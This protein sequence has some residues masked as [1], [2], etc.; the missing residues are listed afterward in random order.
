MKPLY[1]LLFI[2]ALVLCASCEKELK[3]GGLV[4]IDPIRH[5]YPVLQ[6]EP[7]TIS[8]EMEDTTDIPI[9]I[10]EVQT[11]CG[12]IV[13]KTSLPLTVLP[14]KKAFLTLT[15]NTIKNTGYVHH[16]I[17]CYGNFSD[18]STVVLEFDTNI[19]PGADYVRDYEELWTEQVHRGITVR[20]MVDGNASEKGYYTDEQES[21]RTR[22][23]RR[24]QEKLDEMAP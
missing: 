6:G 15:F 3:P 17:Y 7:L 1:V 22:R 10:Q 20:Q 21:P 12:C 19:V 23:T 16:Y 18:S 24:I 11:S 2:F 4:V 9:F 13:P 5:Y 14:H 8:Y